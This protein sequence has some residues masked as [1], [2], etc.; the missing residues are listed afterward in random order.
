[1]FTMPLHSN[2]NYSIVVCVL[3]AVGVCLPT[4]CPAMNVYSDFIIP[5]LGRHITILFFYEFESQALSSVM[6]L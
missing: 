5:A 4:R 2:G 6:M 3:V 1:M